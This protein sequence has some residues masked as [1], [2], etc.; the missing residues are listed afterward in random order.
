MSI[1]LD[2]LNAAESQLRSLINALPN[3][4]TS[5][6]HRLRMFFAQLP[7]DICTDFLYISE[8]AKPE[9]GQSPTIVSQK[10][11]ALIDQCFLTDQIPTFVQG[12]TR[13]Y[14]YAYTLE[15]EDL[16]AAISA[17]ELEK[18]LEFATRSPERCVR[19]ALSDFWKTPHQDFNALTPKEWLSRF[20]VNLILCEARLR[21]ADGTFSANGLELVEH[22]FATPVA[23]DPPLQPG[24]YGCYT[25]VLNGHPVQRPT[26]LHG[27]FVITTKHL[28]TVSAELHD[29]LIIKDAT[30]RPVVL[31]TPNVGLETFDSITSL[32]QELGARIK[33]PYQREL[34]FDCLLT[35][36]RVRA[37]VH[38][39]VDYSPVED[40]RVATF[41][42]TQLI[43]KQQR[44]LRHA[45]SIA[46]THKYDTTLDQLSEYV[47]LF[48][49]S[50][51]PLKPANI[52]NNR[53]TRLLESQLPG[54]LRNAPDE[55]KTQ[56]RLA[57]ERLNHER[58]AS[59]TPDAQPLG[60]IG[61]K[62][63]L[64]GYARIQLQQQ[65]KNDHG[66][67][68][69][70]D[71]IYISTTE[72]VRT[73]PLF[74]PISGSGFAAGVSLDKTG[75]VISYQTT[76]RSLSELALAN[77]GIWDVTFTLTAQV[78]DSTGR[79]HPILAP[80]YVKTLVRQ[81]DIGESY[82]RNLN[83]LLINSAQAHWRK[84][85]Y[86]AVKKAQ[87]HLDL[88][89]ATLSGTLNAEQ[90]EWV[91]TALAHPVEST[92]PRI[93]GEQV[94]AHL[95]MMR[96]KPLPGVLVFSSTASRELLCYTPDAPDKRWFLVANTRN[97]LGQK[98]SHPHWRAYVMRRVTLAQQA[99][100]KPLLEQG[101]T[102]SNL[103][104]QGIGHNL[105]EASYDTEALHAIHDA[106]E[107]STSTWE[108]NLNTAKDTALTVIDIVSFVLPTRVLLP[109]VLSRFIYQIL[110]GIDALQRDEKHEA[111]LHFM[112]S[113]THLTDGAS[114]FTGSAIFSKSIR[115]RIRQPR[116]T[117]SLGA[118]RTPPATGLQLRTGDE[119]GVGVFEQAPSGSRPAAY[120][121]KDTRG[122]LYRSQYDNLDELWRALDARNP[123][124][125]YS[126][127]LRELSAGLWDVDP[128]TPLLKQKFSV[129]RVIE[130]AQVRDLDLSRSSPDEQ[131]LYRVNN[132]LYIQQ[133]DVIL[134]V[135]RGWLGR[136]FYL[137]R[138]TGSSSGISAQYKVRRTAGQWEIK[139]KLAD[140]AKRWEPLSLDRASPSVDLPAIKYSDYDI[141]DEYK[142]TLHGIIRDHTNLFIGDR[143][144][145]DLTSQLSIAHRAFKKMRVKLLADAKTFFV[146]KPAKPRVT[147]PQLASNTSAPDL[148]K[149]L[150]E[151]SPGIILGEAH[152][153]QSGKKLLIDNMAELA[154]SDVKVIYL[155]HL[156]TDMHQS[157]LDD[158]FKTGKMSLR[159]DE[160]LTN[161]DLGHGIDP[162]S[163]Y[164][165]SQLVRQ[166]RRHGI[167]VKALDCAASYHERG[168]PSETPWLNRGE[169]F[170]YFASQIIRADQT[171]TGGHKWIALTGNTHANTFQ[172]IPGLAELE[173]AIGL[174]VS[175]S[176]P[177][178]SQGLRQALGE[179]VPPNLPGRDYHFLKNDY[180]LEVDIPGTKP[181][182]R[183]LTLAQINDRLKAPGY[184]RLDNDSAAGPQLTHRASNHEIIHTP[185]HTDADG[186]IFIERASWP[187][188][189]QKR[190]GALKQLIRDLQ[191]TN[192]MIQVQ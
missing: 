43:E 33:D 115:Q 70:P 51:L 182:P 85:R 129:Q 141:P 175:D 180:W 123:N 167:E 159:L 179:V 12:A 4:D 114:D 28:P 106:D 5:L 156:Q 56:W 139:H 108:S 149:S 104:L 172:G 14:N 119:F 45:W 97:E 77:V 67:E 87:L 54:W 1:A 177:G 29:E 126:I 58:L 82:K 143:D 128:T 109:I 86:V 178:T 91:K 152:A 136:N 39:H 76:R 154:K 100:I 176:V 96:Y 184:F 26:F 148:F 47:D 124:A 30:P 191:N 27:A 131:G 55:Q 83:N 158:F 8:E 142:E 134:E 181:R 107:Q 155:E 48:L 138:P 57:V 21:H 93:N 190:Y 7:E 22:V 9:P 111:L 160:F 99:Y 3:L 125:T 153:H 122:N 171:R 20:A 117:L 36:D 69:N 49:N 88:L 64:L 2:F 150:H 79:T 127:P 174:R 145:V 102:D 90:T 133:N 140:G 170:S 17:P 84:E 53:Y 162:S 42:S 118:A 105:F 25:M 44:D 163:R 173:G 61:Q 110:Q 50:S 94:K 147:R 65:I 15:D 164:N 72:A 35:E 16:A 6:D 192:S 10:L 112:E 166:A 19:D 73:G 130:S 31:Y 185:V 120:Y 34:L 66:I 151:H 144:F 92:R 157:L 98:L 63:T 146:S 188:I 32:S 95:L 62:H 89:E 37:L 68:V 71:T 165:F 52:L 101:L 38:E 80:Q 40:E 137:Q 11:T 13:V 189:H 135:Y 81:L 78:K 168:T 186:L 116:A 23:P 187:T 121:T 183:A 60:E 59:V 132:K 169:M 161:Q 113:I 24:S 46:R 18:Y 41:F 74:N 75:P 103:Q